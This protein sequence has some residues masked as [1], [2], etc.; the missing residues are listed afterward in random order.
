MFKKL[1]D[2][3]QAALQKRQTARELIDQSTAMK[4]EKKAAKLDALL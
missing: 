4:A 1:N 3:R 2:D